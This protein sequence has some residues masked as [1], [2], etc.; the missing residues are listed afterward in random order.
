MAW[1]DFDV[2][3]LLD[4]FERLLEREDLRRGDHGL[5]VRT[6]S[7]HVRQLLG[8]GDV[9]RDVVL[10]RVLADYLSFVNGVHRRDEEAS[11][12]LELV[13]RVGIGRARLARDDRTVGAHLDLADPRFEVLQTV[14]HDRLA[15]RG[16]EHVRPQADDAARGNV[17]LQTHAVAVRGHVLQRALALGGQLDHRARAFL[18]T[19]DRHLLD[20][21]ALAAVDLLD[22]HAGLSHL[23]LVP[24]AAHRLDEHREVQHAAA[25][26]V[27]RIGRRAGRHAQREVLL[28]FAVQPLLDMAR[29]DVFSV[30]AEEGR[31]VDREEHR[32]RG[33]VDG[34]GRRLVPGFS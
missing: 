9:H 21:F 16:G 5:V 27:E 28:Q 12:V 1:G 33:F 17:E 18:G 6:R 14:R 25:E 8:F 7:A 20:G 26:D 32:H 3:V 31:V 23:Q 15:R 11:A 22:D 4:V 29:G 13:D 2:F 19:I 10:A 30:L 34:D 24:F